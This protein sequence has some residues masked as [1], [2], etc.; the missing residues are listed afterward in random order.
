MTIDMMK[1]F[2]LSEAIREKNDKA[3]KLGDTWTHPGLPGFEQ[4]KFEIEPEPVRVTNW[5]WRQRI[6]V[7]YH[8]DG[9]VTVVSRQ[10]K[11]G[12]V[13]ADHKPVPTGLGV[14][15]VFDVHSDIR[16]Y[17]VIQL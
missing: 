8:A 6:S 12:V 17:E 3:P 14:R 15:T 5:T 16:R 11:I 9:S 10:F 2:G 13:G 4:A 7:E 1:T